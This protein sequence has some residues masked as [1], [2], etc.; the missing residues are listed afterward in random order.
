VKKLLC[1]IGLLMAITI[2]AACGSTSGDPQIKVSEPWSRPSPMMAGN[3][4]VYMVLSNE[5]GSDDTLISAETDIA[6]VVEL[7]ETKMENDVMKMSPVHTINIPAGES[8]MLK[9]GGLHVMLI[10]LQKELVPGETVT[11][12]LNFEKSAPITIEAEI[13]EM[14]NMK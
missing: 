9:P 11:L 14:G 1:I 4:A 10:N 8:V 13:R 3:G 12:T 2:I 5:G 6:A 7:H